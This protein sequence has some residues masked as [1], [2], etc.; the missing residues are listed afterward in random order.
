MNSESDNEKVQDAEA[1]Y[2]GVDEEKKGKR[3]KNG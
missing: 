3:K 1:Q 2:E